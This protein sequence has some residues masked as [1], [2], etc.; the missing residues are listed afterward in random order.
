MTLQDDLINYVN[1]QFPNNPVSS[2]FSQVTSIT[3]TFFY[4]FLIAIAFVIVIR[5][6]RR[7][8]MF[9]G[10]G[11]QYGAYSVHWIGGEGYGHGN[12]SKNIWFDEEH[13]NSI[14]TQAPEFKMNFEEFSHLVESE[15]MFVYDF[16]VTDHGKVWSFKDTEDVVIVSNGQMESNEF[17]VAEKNGR[18]S[19]TSA[20]FRETA[21]TVGA[22]PSSRH[23][24]VVD[25]YGKKRDVWILDLIPQKPMKVLNEVITGD[26]YQVIVKT[27]GNMEALAKSVVLLPTLIRQQDEIQKLSSEVEDYRRLLL[28]AQDRNKALNALFNKANEF[29]S[30]KMLVGNTRPQTPLQRVSEIAFTFA[31]FLIP[32]LAYLELP[33]HFPT[34]DPTIVSVISFIVILVMRELWKKE[35]KKQDELGLIDT[36]GVQQM[37]K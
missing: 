24:T 28:K 21:R 16:K 2:I 4:I 20:T 14:K 37:E 5:F 11:P 8:S 35:Q 6:A 33:S 7:Y 31:A 17:S 26:S 15:Q 22:F 13:F 19:F 32:V 3:A 18:F 10:K 34:I 1:Q 9:A 23:Y 12:L 25:P 36:G 29:L 30:Q 27:I